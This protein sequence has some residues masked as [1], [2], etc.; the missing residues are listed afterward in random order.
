MP[1]I[2]SDCSI[3]LLFPA[4][5]TAGETVWRE[6]SLEALSDSQSNSTLLL[7][8]FEC[9]Y[10]LIK[11]LSGVATQFCIFALYSGYIHSYTYSM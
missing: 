2:T 6:R 11:L 10:C 7:A 4:G 1:H 5:I 9:R 3:R 8:P